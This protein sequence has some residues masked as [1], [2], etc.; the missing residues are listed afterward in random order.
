MLFL[1]FRKQNLILAG[2]D[3][4]ASTMIWALSLLLNHDKV[5]K[6]AQDE[7]NTQL[8]GNERLVEESD[9]KNLVHFQAIVKET[10]RLFPPGPLYHSLARP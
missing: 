6:R 10:M 4:S 9:I 7:L 5:L 2:A 1:F 8:V 3:T